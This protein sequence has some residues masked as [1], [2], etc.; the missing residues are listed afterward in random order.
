[1]INIPV[2]D[3]LRPG[4]FRKYVLKAIIAFRK[5]ITYYN[6]LQC[7][8]IQQYDSYYCSDRYYPGVGTFA[9]RRSGLK[10]LC[11]K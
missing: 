11:Q 1:M 6:H 5:E 9:D 3:I 10:F 7:V 4:M 8:E 2:K